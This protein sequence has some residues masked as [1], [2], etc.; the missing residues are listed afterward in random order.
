MSLLLAIDPGTTHSALCIYDSYA[1]KPTACQTLTNSEALDRIQHAPKLEVRDV[2]VEMIASYGMA[3]GREVF[4]TV[5]WIGR[6]VERASVV[7]LTASLM[8]RREVKLH[9][10]GQT[11]AKDPNVRQALM[12]LYGLGKAEAIGTKKMPGPLYGISGDEWAA[13]AVARTFADKRLKQVTFH[14]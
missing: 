1:A 9:L 12:D 7:G 11:S 8:Y 2:V 4:E 3:V 6:F 13:L 14:P 5:L 10:C